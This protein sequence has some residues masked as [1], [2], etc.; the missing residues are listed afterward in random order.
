MANILEKKGF[1]INDGGSV[2]IWQ[3]LTRAHVP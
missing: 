3:T 1:T 2:E